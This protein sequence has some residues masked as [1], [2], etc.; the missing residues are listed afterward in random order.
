LIFRE[1]IVIGYTSTAAG[2]A[3]EGFLALGR[4]ES[5]GMS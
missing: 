5:D 4:V 1:A 2:L 3:E